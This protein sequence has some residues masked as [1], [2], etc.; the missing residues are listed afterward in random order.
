MKK[1]EKPLDNADDIIALGKAWKRRNRG[2]QAAANPQR[3]AP[4]PLPVL[5]TTDELQ[6]SLAVL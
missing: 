3:Q 5:R 6:K 4:G 2:G 1:P